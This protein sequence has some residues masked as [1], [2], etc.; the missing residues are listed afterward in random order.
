MT[1]L[2]MILNDTKVNIAKRMI[3]GNEPLKKILLYT[4]LEE[5]VILKLQEELKS[6]SDVLNE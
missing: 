2:E 3:I 4:K 6:D 1:I 5:Q